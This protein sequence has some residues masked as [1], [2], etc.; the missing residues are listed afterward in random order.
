MSKAFDKVWT[1]GLKYKIITI[2]DLPSIL[3]K[4][5]CSYLEERTAQI[6]IENTISPKIK[7]ESGVPQGVILSPTM[8]ILYTRDIPHPGRDCMDVLFVDDITQVI[9]N[10]TK[11]QQKIIM[12][13][14]DSWL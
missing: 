14:G 8:Y 13:T 1:S 6:K 9:V 11:E 10:N 2:E 4:I 5:M 7:L 3:E 12:T